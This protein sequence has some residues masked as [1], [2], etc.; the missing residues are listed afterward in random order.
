MISL[1]LSSIKVEKV[2]IVEG[3]YHVYAEIVERPLYC[4][5]C[6]WEIYRHDLK[7]QLIYDIPHGH[8]RVGIILTRRRY[9]CRGPACGITFMQKCS[10]VDDH[11]RATKRLV[12]YIKQSAME[13][14]CT[15]VSAE[16][17]LSEKTIRNI[18]SEYVVEVEKQHKFETPEILGIDEVHLNKQMRLVL[19]NIGARTIIDLRDNRSRKTVESSIYRFKNLHKIELVTIDMWRPYRDAAA[20]VIPHA[21]VIVDKFHIVKMANE[22]VEKGRKS[23]REEM[24]PELFKRL[25]KDKW[26]MVKRRRDLTEFDKAMLQAWTDDYPDLCALYEAKESLFDIWDQVL[27]RSQAE[28]AYQDWKDSIPTGVRKYFSDVDRA[29]SNWHKEA[30]NY[31]DHRETN[32]FTESANNLIKSIYRRGRGYS[33]DVLRARVLFL[34]SPHRIVRKPFKSNLPSGTL[35]FMMAETS[36]Y[37]VEVPHYDDIDD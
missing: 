21:K 33:F 15:H 37:G 28:T 32:A 5:E 3:D 36:D 31:F 23:L 2:E 9:K 16:V 29:V 11:H 18:L 8:H 24:E 25:K 35:G 7:T 34:H 20:G 30:F 12:D 27:T 14:P 1:K 10:D 6:V 26:L 17:G 19:T 13:R 22:A 4:P